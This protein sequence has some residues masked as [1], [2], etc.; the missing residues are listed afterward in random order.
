MDCH[1]RFDRI[2]HSDWPM[3]AYAS[4]ATTIR[5]RDA[6]RRAGWRM[7]VSPKGP[8][9]VDDIPYALDNGAWWAHQQQQPFDNAAFVNCVERLGAGADWIVAPD[10]VGGGEASLDKSLQ[11]TEYLS[12]FRLVLLAVQDGMTVDMVRPWLSPKVGIF[13]GG[14]TEWKLAS[15]FAW[16]SL[17]RSRGAYCHVGRVNTVVRIRQCAAAGVNSFDGSSPTKFSVTLGKLDA[18]RRVA[19][20]YAPAREGE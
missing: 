7:L 17:A 14:T 4:N 8:Q 1:A 3:I 18:S 2:L 19:D 11:W 6:L 10:I 12:R 9:K 13:I 15:M 16:A 5:N 20:L